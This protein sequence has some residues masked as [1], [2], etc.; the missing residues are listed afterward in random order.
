MV[1]AT[2]G[3]G[4]KLISVLKDMDLQ[5]LGSGIGSALA[6]NN[7]DNSGST[8]PPS[9][10]IDTGA[11]RVLPG[12]ELILPTPADSDEA[13]NVFSKSLSG[14][15]RDTFNRLEEIKRQTEIETG[16]SKEK[17][18]RAAQLQSD[19]ANSHYMSLPTRSA[20][21]DVNQ[22]RTPNTDYDSDLAF[23]RDN[24]RSTWIDAAD[25]ARAKK[26]E[27]YGSDRDFATP[28]DAMTT[29]TWEA[30]AW[31]EFP[32][33]LSGL[34]QVGSPE[35]NQ[36]PEE[37]PP[38]STLPISPDT[39][40]T[41]DAP[42]TPDTSFIPTV[43]DSSYPWLRNSEGDRVA[44]NPYYNPFWDSEEEISRWNTKIEN[45][46]VP[47]G[48]GDWETVSWSANDPFG[49]EPRSATM[50]KL[51]SQLGYDLGYS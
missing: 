36:T 19:I 11:T 34:P 35:W 2:P 21:A 39:P 40:D 17:A 30:P 15:D 44:R 48:Y 22:F 14:L 16:S 46:N 41:P 47:G 4:A 8:P 25:M 42:D 10:G 26:L 31:S 50:T 6:G 13:A 3:L 51:G 9:N 24:A 29:K 5:G 18:Y 45:P 38:V 7:N 43:K 27:A 49:D 32:K 1:L 33:G 12:K 37:T 20:M 28:K 23:T